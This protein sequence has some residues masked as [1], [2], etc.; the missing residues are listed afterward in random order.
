MPEKPISVQKLEEIET[1]ETSPLKLAVWR[2]R[3]LLRD[4]LKGRDVLDAE[5]EGSSD[6]TKKVRQLYRKIDE[7]MLEFFPGLKKTTPKNVVLKRVRDMLAQLDYPVVEM[8]EDRPWGAF[9][10]LDDGQAER[11]VREFF[12]GLSHSEAKLG[13]DDVELSPK[14]LV[15][16]PG[17]RL[18]WQFHHRRAERWRFLT[19]GAY[20]SSNTDDQG[21]IITVKAGQSVQ[22]AKGERH[23]LCAKDDKNYVLVAEIWQHTDPARP[24][25]ENDIVRLSDDYARADG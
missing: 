8:D 5:S 23:R 18:S 7:F 25:D 24:T 16:A 1:G 20:Y 10:R 3:T 2:T 6:T 11:F 13:Q 4:Q 19:D 14:I 21:D 9:Y 12:P 22:L 17:Q 15:V